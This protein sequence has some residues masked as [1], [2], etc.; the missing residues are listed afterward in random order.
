M[1]YDL[2]ILFFLKKGQVD[3]KGGIPIY[4]RITV[5]GERVEVSTNQ[6]IEVSKWDSAVQRAKGRSET[7]R[8]L[9]DS[10]DNS[11][12]RVKRDF[13]SLIEKEEIITSEKLKD[14][15]N[16]KYLKYY[17]LVDI[18][19]KNNKLVELEVGSKYTND[20]FARY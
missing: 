20:T 17:Y 5:N 6:K 10:L 3:K 19:E 13:N 1:Q 16:G 9:N 11:E 8:T 2:S 15:L 4:L 7:A 12:N 18:F 14:M